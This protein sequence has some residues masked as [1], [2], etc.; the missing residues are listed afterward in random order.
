MMMMID[1]DYNDDDATQASAKR[2]ADSQTANVCAAGVGLS[3]GCTVG[4]D[5]VAAQGAR[6]PGPI[7]AV[8]CQ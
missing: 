3:G 8:L 4:P 2:W 7:T 6:A 1:D 5:V